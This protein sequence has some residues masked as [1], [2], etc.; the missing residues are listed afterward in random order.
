MKMNTSK[1]LTGTV[2]HRRLEITVEHE[3]VSMWVRGST[4]ADGDWVTTVNV[5][6]DRRLSSRS[7]PEDPATTKA[8]NPLGT[9]REFPKGRTS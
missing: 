5:S 3:S 4:P 2:V 1:T 7:G 6:L 9:D 8:A